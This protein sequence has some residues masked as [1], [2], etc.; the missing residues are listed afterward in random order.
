LNTPPQVDGILGGLSGPRTAAR[1]VSGPSWRSG[2]AGELIV[3]DTAERAPRPLHRRLSHNQR[4]ALIAAF[5]SGVKQRDL[6]VQYG[7]SIRSIKR[8]VRAARGTD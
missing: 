2:K 6:A 8:L 5:D 1:G 4:A 7:I 3:E